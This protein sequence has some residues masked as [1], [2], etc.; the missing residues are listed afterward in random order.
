MR[1]GLLGLK[2]KNDKVIM[3]KKARKVFIFIID[4]NQG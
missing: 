4:L 2:A 3:S 1:I